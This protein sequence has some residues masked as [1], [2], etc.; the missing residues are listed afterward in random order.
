[1]YLIRI[2]LSLYAEFSQKATTNKNIIQNFLTILIR[3]NKPSS[4]VILR[5]VSI[6]HSTITTKIT[7]DTIFGV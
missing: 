7:Q 5:D 6:E 2:Y 3:N 1:M 4:H